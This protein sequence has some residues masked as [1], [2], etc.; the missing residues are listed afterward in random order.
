MFLYLLTAVVNKPVWFVLS[1][2]VAIFPF[3][4]HLGDRHAGVLFSSASIAVVVIASTRQTDLFTLCFFY[5]SHKLS[6]AVRGG[7]RFTDDI[8]STPVPTAPKIPVKPVEPIRDEIFAHN[9]Y[10]EYKGGLLEAEELK[11]QALYQFYPPQFRNKNK[12]FIFQLLNEQPGYSP[13][14]DKSILITRWSWRPF[15]SPREENGVV[16]KVVFVSDSFD[17]RQDGGSPTVQWYLNFADANLFA[18]YAG[19]LLAQDELQVLECPELAALS[20]YF[21]QTTSK[22]NPETSAHV[23]DSNRAVPTPS[24]SSVSRRALANRAHC[25]SY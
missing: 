14:E 22:I 2:E 19:G 12:Q 23:K 17:Y 21:V 5:C 4:I 20:E 8:V 16:T 13:S 24:E 1:G 9:R 15:S 25:S 3:Y 18:F 7:S 11:S 10:A 6:M